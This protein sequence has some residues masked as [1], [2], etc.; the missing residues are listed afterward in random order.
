MPSNP[1]NNPAS[2]RPTTGTGGTSVPGAGT[3]GGAKAGIKD[4]ARQ[5]KDQVAEKAHEAGGQVKQQAQQKLDEARQQAAAKLRDGK[6]RVAGQVGTV[7]H[8]FRSAGDE[9]RGEEQARLAEFTDGAAERMEHVARYIDEH[10]VAEMLDDVERLARK[11]PSLFLG[12]AFALGMVGARFMKTSERRRH[13]QGSD[14]EAADVYAGEGSRTLPRPGE[15]GAGSYSTGAPASAGTG[16]DFSS[17]PPTG[18]AHA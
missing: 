16:A 5:V 14:F 17:S 4:S 10:S 1:T 15:T 13:H 7:A 9:L 18:G 12:G 6:S 3:T 2:N 8:A 11:S